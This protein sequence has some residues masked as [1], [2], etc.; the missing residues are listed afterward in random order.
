MNHST[1]HHRPTQPTKVGWGEPS[2]PPLHQA[3]WKAPLPPKQPVIP[4]H[5]PYTPKGKGVWDVPFSTTSSWGQGALEGVVP[6]T[7]G[8]AVQGVVPRKR[9]CLGRG[10]TPDRVSEGVAP[11]NWP[12]GQALGL[13]RA[14]ARRGRAL[15]QG[16]SWK[17]APLRRRHILKA[18]RVFTSITVVLKH[19]QIAVQIC[20]CI[21]KHNFC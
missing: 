15:E 1:L 9:W 2:L 17:R 10:R 12:G 3:S 16:G 20:F 8:C 7:L 11:G 14:V 4:T 6:W 19:P 18:Q 13:E 5:P 21:Y